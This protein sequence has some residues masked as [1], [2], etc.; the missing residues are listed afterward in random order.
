MQINRLLE[1]IYILLHKK[2]ISARELAEQLGVSS[3]TIYRDIDALSLAGIPI[4]TE[5]GKGGGIGLL[6]DFVLNKSILS[7]QEQNEILSALHG[8]S[9]IKTDDTAQVLQ[10]LSA[11]FNKT[12]TNWLEVD[13]SDWHHDADLFNDFKVAILERR[14]VQFDYY[15][16]HGENRLRRVEPIQLWF[17]GKAWYLKGF[18]LTKQDMRLYKLSR[19]KHLL[20]T[21]EH[22]SAREFKDAS[23]DSAQDTGEDL[24]MI[25]LK[26]RIAQEMA[27]RVYDDFISREIERQPD[28]SFLITAIMPETH[29]VYGFLLSYRS[30]VEVLEPAHIRRILKDE[31]EQISKKHS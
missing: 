16:S 31:A 11:T 5:K 27:Y 15:N 29:G 4:Y 20:V 24:Q 19:I 7:E 21:D 10:K 1:I 22:F 12:A 9:N 25:T 3:R 18:C 28:G 14:I 13:F 30:F 8:L 17:K 6:P 23:G 26:L 2:S